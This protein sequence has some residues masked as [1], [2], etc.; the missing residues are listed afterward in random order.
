[1]AVCVIRLTHTDGCFGQAAPLLLEDARAML[2]TE[3]APGTR[4]ATQT[5][6][7]SGRETY[8]RLIDHRPLSVLGTRPTLADRSPGARRQKSLCAS[9]APFRSTA[10]LRASAA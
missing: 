10:I 9:P 1:M 4:P 5:A 7:Q 3:E 2:K 8:C 6:L